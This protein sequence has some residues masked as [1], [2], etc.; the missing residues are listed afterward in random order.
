MNFDLVKIVK[1]VAPSNEDVLLEIRELQKKHPHLNK[2]QL[3]KKFS[4]KIVKYYTSIGI[5]SALPSVIPGVGT[6]SQITIEASTVSADFALLLRWMAK[7]CYG[8]GI[9]NNYDMSKS[10]NQ[11]FIRILGIWS[12]VIIGVKE[13]SKIIGTITT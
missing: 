3:S 10:F 7:I 9:I 2:Q 4:N 8:V 6:V 1:T 13:A 5:G 12:G 11:D